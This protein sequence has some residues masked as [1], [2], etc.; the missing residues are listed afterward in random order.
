MPS[1]SP[2]II[3][4][5]TRLSVELILK[6]PRFSAAR[7]RKS[8]PATVNINI[9]AATKSACKTVVSFVGSASRFLR[10]TRK[11]TL[12]NAGTMATIED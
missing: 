5:I 11:T 4:D 12:K 2:S 6:L 10:I 8:H 9:A 3:D 7:L 1:I